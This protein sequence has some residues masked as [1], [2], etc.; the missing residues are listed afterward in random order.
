MTQEG[1]RCPQLLPDLT[2]LSE[3]DADNIMYLASAIDSIPTKFSGK[4]RAAMAHLAEDAIARIQA[5]RF[6][7]ER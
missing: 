2:N 6:Q 3:P 7:I 4:K 1:N 5:Q